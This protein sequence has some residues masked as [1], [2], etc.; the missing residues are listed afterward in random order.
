MQKNNKIVV[1]IMAIISGFI[2]GAVVM[3]ASGYSPIDA[4]GA[5]L[6]GAGF[7]EI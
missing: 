4:Y 7:L 2:I 1:S 3:L 6:K 5:L